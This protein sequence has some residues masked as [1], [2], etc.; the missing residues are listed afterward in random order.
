MDIRPASENSY[1]WGGAATPYEELGGEGRVRELADAFYDIVD[2]SSPVLRAMLPVDLSVSRQK[3]FEFLSGWMGGPGLYWER[4]GH[5]RLRMRHA[6]FPID[7]HAADEWS[8]CMDGALDRI[9]ADKAVG[10]YLAEELGK[11]AQSL[12]NLASQDPLI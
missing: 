3:L 2:E 8:R 11:A 7:N 10:A 12:R 6:R 5:P 4:H 1:P 9:G